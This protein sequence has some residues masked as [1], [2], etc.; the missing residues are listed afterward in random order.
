MVQYHYWAYV[1]KSSKRESI[2]SGIGWVNEVLRGSEAV[3][4]DNFRMSSRTFHS[5]VDAV[6]KTGTL[7]G[8]REVC[9][10]EQVAMFL[11]FIGHRASSRAIKCRFQRSGETV[12]RHLHAV[13]ASLVNLCPTNIRIPHPG[14]AVHPIRVSACDVS[15]FQSRKGVIM[16]VLTACDFDFTFVMAGWEGTAGDGKLYD[17]A[18]R[19]GLHIDDAKFD[20][21]DAGFALTTKA[22]T[23]YRGKRYH[24]KEFAR[25]RQRPQSK[26][27][28][29]NL[30]H[31]QLR[32]VVERIFG[33]LKKRF[34]VLV[35]PVEYNYK[36][37]VDLVLALCL[38]HNFIRQHGNDSFEEE[39]VDEI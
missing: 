38:L 1:L 8:G 10:E 20:I 2:L 37:Q 25:G 27:E 11:Y 39:V 35:C 18:L 32:N 33:I 34:L 4:I 23:S 21:L 29:F 12:T 9:I 19:M 15:R 28:F 16:N 24:L 22:R 3:V 5:L 6:V 14:G 26:E 17:A 13:M 36:F 7:V 31:A 30:R